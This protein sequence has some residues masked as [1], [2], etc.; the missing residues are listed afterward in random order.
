MS[1]ATEISED[2]E[3]DCESCLAVRSIFYLTIYLS[4]LACIYF[5]LFSLSR[6]SFADVPVVF[7]PVADHVVPDWQPRY[8]LL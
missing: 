5:I 3:R 4:F 6:W 1:N 8:I 7:S 2:F